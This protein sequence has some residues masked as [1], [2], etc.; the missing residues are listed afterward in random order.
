MVP[1]FSNNWNSSKTKWVNR[2]VVEAAAMKEQKGVC[3]IQNI[4]GKLYSSE[5][6]CSHNFCRGLAKM[7]FYKSDRYFL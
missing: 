1:S 5:R 2:V 6:E 3:E 4:V 7:Y